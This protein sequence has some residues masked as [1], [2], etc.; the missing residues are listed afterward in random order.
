MT[1]STKVEPP[2]ADALC[3]IA[4][5]RRTTIPALTRWWYY[6]LVQTHTPRQGSQNPPPAALQVE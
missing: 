5:A 3:A 6:R 1:L 4:R 2:I